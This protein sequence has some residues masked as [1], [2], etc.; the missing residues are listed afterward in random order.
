MT[1][2]FLDRAVDDALLDRSRR[3]TVGAPSEGVL[4]LDF[5]KVSDLIED[6]AMSMFS[7]ARR[8]RPCASRGDARA[9]AAWRIKCLS[10]RA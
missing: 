3:R 8:G 5:K 4:T 10:D 6:V 2:R 1:A 9:I 7:T